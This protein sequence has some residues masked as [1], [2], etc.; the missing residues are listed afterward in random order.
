[1]N[2]EQHRELERLRWQWKDVHQQLLDSHK[3]HVSSIRELVELRTLQAEYRWLMSQSKG[4]SEAIR[5]ELE[6]M[7][8]TPDMS[9]G[10][11][12]STLKRILA[13]LDRI[14]AEVAAPR[15]RS[16]WSFHISVEPPDLWL[17]LAERLRQ[18]EGGW[19]A[20][21]DSW[22]LARP[23]AHLEGWPVVV[24]DPAASRIMPPTLFLTAQLFARPG[25]FEPAPYTTPPEGWV[26]VPGDGPEPSGY[27]WIDW[28]DHFPR[29]HDRLYPDVRR[30]V[31]G[32]AMLEK[33]APGDWLAT[34]YDVPSEPPMAQ[35]FLEE[36]AEILGGLYL[37]PGEGA[38]STRSTLLE[39]RDDWEWKLERVRE[40]VEWLRQGVGQEA[41]ARK[42]SRT[43]KR[44][45]SRSTLND[46]RKRAEELGIPV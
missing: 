14:Q 15:G 43:A 23:E 26:A 11:R 24:E 29:K 35:G 7:E 12:L 37:Q 42:V 30:Y 18:I 10:A 13:D 16:D 34:L 28:C 39:E 6:E 44:D 36:V 38:S 21:D 40:Y 20:G 45:L 9:A 22:L 17:S 1:V 32:M 5:A 27:D 8:R 33:R 46:W 31:V 3:R 19:P 2:E 25:D 4:K 41:A